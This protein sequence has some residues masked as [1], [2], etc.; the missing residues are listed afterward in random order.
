[1]RNESQEHLTSA[2]KTLMILNY[3][4]H[5]KT[6][7]E[8]NTREHWAPKARRKK[9]HRALAKA[10]TL[11]MLGGRDIA[12]QTVAVSLLRIGQ[13]KLDD[14]NLQ[15]SFKAI[16][17]GICDAVGIDDGDER[18]QFF[19]DQ[20]ATGKREYSVVVSVKVGGTEQNKTTRN[21]RESL[22]GES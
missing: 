1:M 3:R 2:G 5:T 8:A 12:G 9:Q 10:V 20:E 18:I 13:K 4:L 14:D 22:N 15:S 7:S 6:V 17:D 21:M 19:Y 11:S 16:R